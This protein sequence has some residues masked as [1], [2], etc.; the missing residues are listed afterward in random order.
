MLAFVATIIFVLLD[1]NVTRRWF[2][3]YIPNPTYRAVIRALLFFTII[4][5]VD[6]MVMWWRSEHPICGERVITIS[7]DEPLED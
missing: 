3:Q 5:L 4:Y 2:E 1:L 7:F 6:K